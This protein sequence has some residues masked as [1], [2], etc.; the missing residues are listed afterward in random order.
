MGR[1]AEWTD[2]HR[3]ATSI[4]LW[5]VAL[6]L[7]GACL[8]YQD[9]TGPT[10]PLEGTVKT[11]KG[12]VHFKFMR[13]ENIGVPLQIALVNPPA[14]VKGD[15]K[16]R[17][18]KSNDSWLTVG[19]APNTFRFERR[20]SVQ[21]VKGVGLALPSLTERA[22]KYEYFV[23]VDDGTGKQF[24]VTGEKPIYARY[25][26]EVPNAVLIVHVLTIFI[27][28]LFAIR[29][30][31]EAMLP[32]GRWRWMIWAT[33]VSLILGGFVLGPLV[34]WYAFGV[35]WSGVPFGWDWTDNKV[36]FEL[37]AW[38]VAIVLN[39]GKRTERWSVLAAGG[40]TLLVYFIPHSIFGSEYDY[41]KGSGQG[42]AG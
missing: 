40:I 13:S 7:T 26:A 18:Y 27:S 34:Q 11:S 2:K 38:I 19:M 29:T 15:V 4:I 23:I 1:I 36:L 17:R 9:T 42:T 3:V 14:G 37:V 30:T 41:T 32:H 8:L 20:G 39:W 6:L 21:E 12:P 35:W 31:L 10:S 16:F 25:K 5:A 28:L 33:L 24:S 22:G